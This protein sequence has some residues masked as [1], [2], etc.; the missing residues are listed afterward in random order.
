MIILKVKI[1]GINTIKKEGKDPFYVLHCLDTVPC[2]TEFCI[3]QKT[4]TCI[5][6]KKGY[7]V[8]SLINIAFC[9]GRYEVCEI[10]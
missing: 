1:V 7:T 2:S 8:G 9:N 4:Y 6:F 5:S 10:P 3:G